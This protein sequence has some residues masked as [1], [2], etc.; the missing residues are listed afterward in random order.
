MDETDELKKLN[1]E[2]DED[3][4]KVEVFVRKTS[5]EIT[6]RC[7]SVV[8]SHPFHVMAL[9]CMAQFV[10]GETNYSSWNV[11]HNIGEIYKN[12][13]VSGFFR[14]YFFKNFK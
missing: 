14:Y 11:F 13:G 5:K 8:L 4:K 12:E 6:V 10:G 3:T 9:R 7:W 2:E 1:K